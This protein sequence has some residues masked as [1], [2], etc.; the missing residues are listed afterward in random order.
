[1]E[2]KE[3]QLNEVKS[4]TIQQ[5]WLKELGNLKKKLQ[6]IIIINIFPNRL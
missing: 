5:M 4:N 6:T 3:A 1:M 2:K